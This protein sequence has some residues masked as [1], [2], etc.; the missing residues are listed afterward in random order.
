MRCQLHQF[1]WFGRDLLRK[2]KSLLRFV[3]VMGSIESVQLAWI[4][5]CWSQGIHAVLEGVSVVPACLR[6]S[7]SN[8]GAN[9]Y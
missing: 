7:P 3:V 2:K 1:F 6:I 8:Q 5:Y 9:I 4:E